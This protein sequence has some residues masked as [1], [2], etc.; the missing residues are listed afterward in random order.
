[1]S[2]RTQATIHTF[3]EETCAGEVITDTGRVLPFSG[4]VFVRSGLRMA[5][6]GQRL[7]IEVG[8]D[9]INRIWMDGVGPGQVIR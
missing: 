4:A 1:M 3:D 9:G 5:R 2:D 8:P 6:L 7:N